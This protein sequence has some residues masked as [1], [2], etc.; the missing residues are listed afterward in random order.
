MYHG[1][2]TDAHMSIGWYNSETGQWDKDEPDLPAFMKVK[3]A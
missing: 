3:D 2:V 1:D